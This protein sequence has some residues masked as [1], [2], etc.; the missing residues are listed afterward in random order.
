MKYWEKTVEYAFLT[1][2]VQ[3]RK[4]DF[5]APLSGK[6]ERGAGDA[7]FARDSRYILLEFKMDASGMGDEE[8]KFL[9]YDTA[10]KAL[11]TRDHHHFFVYGRRTSKPLELVSRTYFSDKKPTG[12]GVSA[13]DCFADGVDKTTFDNYLHEFLEYRRPDERGGG[14]GVGI[15]DYA[16]VIGVAPDNESATACSLRDYASHF[17][18]GHVSSPASEPPSSAPPKGP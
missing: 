3:K 18:L 17:V 16:T 6:L 11:A 12:D 2:A 8:G 5:A 15:S 7:L 1:L 10:K 13:L 9:D 14:G 4:V